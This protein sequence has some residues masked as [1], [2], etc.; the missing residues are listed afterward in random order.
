MTDPSQGAVLGPLSPAERLAVLLSGSDPIPVGSIRE[1]LRSIRPEDWKEVFALAHAHH[2]A[3]RLWHHLN[4]VAAEMPAEAAAAARQLYHE[5]LRIDLR[6]SAAMEELAFRLNGAGARAVFVKGLALS[7]GFSRD[8]PR[9]S[10]DLDLLI[11][12]GL[13]EISR[14][15]D[16]AGSS[17]FHFSKREKDGVLRKSWQGYL[18]ASHD[19]P[20]LKALPDGSSVALDIHRAPSVYHTQGAAHEALMA[21]LETQKTE[22]PWQAVTP[23]GPR[24]VP[25][26]SPSGCMIYLAINLFKDG[27]Y[28][29]RN[30]DDLCLL[31][32]ERSQGIHWQEIR[33]VARKTGLTIAVGLALELARQ[34]RNVPIPAAAGSFPLYSRLFRPYLAPSFAVRSVLEGGVRFPGLRG[35]VGGRWAPLLFGGGHLWKAWLAYE[36]ERLAQRPARTLGRAFYW[37]ARPFELVVHAVS[38]LFRVPKV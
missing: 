16:L 13:P 25:G 18:A 19:C 9:G 22:I 29:L 37:A 17:G 2:I 5:H 11:F 27:H 33:A 31:L 36:R 14:V 23:S 3:G 26:L 24:V 6:Q 1:Q 15:V 4:P 10:G 32:R 34:W 8:L 38:L 35:A 21:W 28:T 7:A 30:I 12:G 20:L